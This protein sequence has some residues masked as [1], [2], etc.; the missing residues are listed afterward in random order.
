MSLPQAVER[1]TLDAFIDWEHHQAERHV[2]FQGEVFAMTGARQAHVQVSLNVASG[3]KQHLRGSP[4]RTFISDMKLRIDA[5]DTVFYPDVMVSCDTRD[6]T[7]THHIE[8]PLLV[9]EVLSASTERFDRGHK[10]QVCRTLPSLREYVLVDIPL[11]RT[12]V[13]RRNP[14]GVWELH[15]FA[16]DQAVVLASV[17]LQLPAALLYEDVDEGPQAGEEAGVAPA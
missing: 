1:M 16:G 13:Y 2:F 15:E 17:E 10:F 4:C 3:L 6:R 5:Q 9:L 14:Q 11:R 7:L 12:E 8:S